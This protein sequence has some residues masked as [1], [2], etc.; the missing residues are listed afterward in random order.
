MQIID[1]PSPNFS[2]RRVSGPLQGAQIHKTLGLMPG[3]LEWL[4]NHTSYV[5]SHYL[6]TRKGEIHKLVDHDKR[7]WSSG[8]LN[9]PSERAR[10]I[11]QKTMWGS[12][13]SPDHYLLQ[14]E[15]ECLAN[16]TYTEQQ[17]DACVWLFQNRLDE[18]EIRDD[19]LITHR[20]TA[21]DKPNLE[22]EREEI[23]SRLATGR[24]SPTERVIL[25]EGEIAMITVDD[26]V[27]IIEKIET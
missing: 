5:S 11:L 20:D 7:P 10:K 25:K 9:R 22:T 3:T 12:Y 26:G 18:T 1:S 2:P 14:I 13:I 15:F 16:Q 27:C 17:Y 8:R 24:P 6:I 19:N 4:R 21:I 23:L